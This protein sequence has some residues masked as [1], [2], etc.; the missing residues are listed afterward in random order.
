V[1]NGNATTADFIA[2]A[3]GDSH[4]SLRAFFEQWLY[5]PGP[6]VTAQ[7]APPARPLAAAQALAARGHRRR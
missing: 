7:A 5:T 4:R 2:L 1:A 6:V 3:Q